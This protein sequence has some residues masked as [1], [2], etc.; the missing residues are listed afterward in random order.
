MACDRPD[1]DDLERST[2]RA[3]AIA[4][5]FGDI[6]LE[7]RALADSGLALVSQGRSREGFGRLD[8]ALAAIAA[9]EVHDPAIAG[10]ELLRHVVV[11]RPRR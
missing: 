3:L 7:V 2:E 1:V 4:R 11:V 9:G 10:Q 8:E 6:G 5:E